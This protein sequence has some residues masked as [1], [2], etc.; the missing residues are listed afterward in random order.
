[1]SDFYLGI[2]SL[3]AVFSFIGIGFSL[4]FFY[5]FAWERIKDVGQLIYQWYH[6]NKRKG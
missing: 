6:L 3:F 5:R 2:Q 1:M 4:G